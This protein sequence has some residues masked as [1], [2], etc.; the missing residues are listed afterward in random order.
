MRHSSTVNNTLLD[1]KACISTMAAKEQKLKKGLELQRFKESSA[2][3]CMFIKGEA[4]NGKVSIPDASSKPS[5][6][7]NDISVLLLLAGKMVTTRE[8]QSARAFLIMPE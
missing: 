3:Q 7:D 4:I 6:R 8:M 5:A 2:D 1:G